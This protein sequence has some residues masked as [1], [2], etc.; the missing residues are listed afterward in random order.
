MGP[1]K[2]YVTCL[3][4]F[5]TPF[6]FVTLC[7]FYSFTSPVLFTKLHEEII[8]SEKEDFLHIWLHQHIALYISKEVENEIFRHNWILKH[9]CMYK[10]P[11]LTK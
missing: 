3:I 9:A 11:A 5:F 10:Q 2:K 6:N 1:F 4:A 8:E 7:Q